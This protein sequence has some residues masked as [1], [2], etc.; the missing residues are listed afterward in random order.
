MPVDIS[1]IVPV[2]DEEENV[3]PLAREIAGA[4]HMESRA[5]ELVFVDDGSR[6]KTWDRIQEAHERLEAGEVF[7]KLVLV[8]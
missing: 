8:P 6:D 5:F 1:I 3:L 7:G 2:F 4:L